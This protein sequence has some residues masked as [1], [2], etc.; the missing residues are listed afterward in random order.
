LGDKQL[1]SQDT[2]RHDN[3][4][5]G[6]LWGLASPLTAALIFFLVPMIA[7]EMGLF[8]M[9][10][11]WFTLGALCYLLVLLF[12]GKMSQLV[13]PKGFRFRVFLIGALQAVSTAL[14]FG[15]LIV[16]DPAP[17]SFLANG[18][19]VFTVIFSAIFLKE[20]LS[21]GQIF[22]GL[23]VIAGALVM[24]WAGD[25]G[26]TLG[27][28]LILSSAL[29]FSIHS[30]IVRQ[31]TTEVHPASIG[32]WR[33][34]AIG[35]SFLIVALFKGEPLIPATTQTGLLLV[36]GA[37]VGPFLSIFTYYQALKNWGAGKVDLLRASLPLWV[38]VL[39]FIEGG[40]LP[41]PV[42][43]IGGGVTVLGVVLL[44]LFRSHQKQKLTEAKS[45]A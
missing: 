19:T 29:T 33:C 11:I 8:G 30:L 16:S 26:T 38:L 12:G 27:A 41:T 31:I 13:P 22:G 2:L 39:V 3:P 35:I 44:L 20:R 7:S 21:L 42:R 28:V 36:I 5:A 15:A 24:T 34:L 40:E 1:T 4:R 10:P 17:T 45:A 23:F 37:I 32:F 14:F 6:F 25:A 18:T 43:L 9:G